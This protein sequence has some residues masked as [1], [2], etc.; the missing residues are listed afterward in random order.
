MLTGLGG[1]LTPY[2]ADGREKTVRVVFAKT[3]A[4]MAQPGIFLRLPSS[5]PEPAVMADARDARRRTGAEEKNV[6]L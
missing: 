4:H 2:A 1:P 5:P 6:E 3:P